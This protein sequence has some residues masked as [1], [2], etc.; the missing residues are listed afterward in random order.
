MREVLAHYRPQIDGVATCSRGSS[1]TPRQYF[2]VSAHREE[3]VDAP[4]GLRELL[5]VLKRSPS[6][7]ALPV[8]VSTHPRT[9][10]RLEALRARR[11]IRAIACIKPLGFLDY[12]KL[13][14]DARVRA[15]G[16]R[17]DHRGSR[18]S[19]TS[20]R[21]TSARRTSGPKAWKRRSS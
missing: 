1:S 17:H 15:V 21:S 3:N 5:D 6:T 2:L 20:P 14:I 11:S 13:Q 18:R 19:S 9:R 4:T 8:I 7:S 10:K 12:V 16:Q